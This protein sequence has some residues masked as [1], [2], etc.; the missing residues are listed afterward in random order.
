MDAI[1]P[2]AAIVAVC[3]LLAGCSPR[4]GS[5][6]WCQGAWDLV[7]NADAKASEVRELALGRLQAPNTVGSALREC[8]E[9][10][11]APAP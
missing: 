11:W 6:R 10:G 7:P 5:D 1:R 9:R 3:I 8:F 4:R 2:R